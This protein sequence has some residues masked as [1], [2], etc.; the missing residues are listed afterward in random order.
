ML[1]QSHKGLSLKFVFLFL[2]VAFFLTAIF[3][4]TL[5]LFFISLFLFLATLLFRFIIIFFT[6]FSHFLAELESW[7]FRSCLQKCNH[8][9]IMI[10]NN[11][12][13]IISQPLSGLSRYGNVI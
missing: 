3:F 10:F 9:V 7:F 4:T 12:V 5:S 6:Q 2:L 1:Y 11:V 13:A 8:I